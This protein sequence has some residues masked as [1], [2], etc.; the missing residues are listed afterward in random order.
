[1]AQ[2][3][4]R[5]RRRKHRGTQGGAL[6]RRGPRGRPRTREEAKARARQSR[7][8]KGKSKQQFDRRDMVPTWASAFKRGAFGAAVFLVML[9][10]LF[11]RPIGEAAA[12]SVVMLGM[13]VPLGYYIDRF[14]YQRRVR[15]LQA[16]RAAK[17]Q[18]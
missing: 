1:M 7:S 17:Q 16:A 8:A 6:D 14:M 10:L 3:A 11:K 12:L 13:Y 4:K 2:Q 15:K 18:R 9:A 5:K